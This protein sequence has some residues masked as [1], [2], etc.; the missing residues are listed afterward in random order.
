MLA[1]MRLEA[2]N[3]RWR[4]NLVTGEVRESDIDDLNTEFNKTNRST[5][6][7]VAMPTTNA[8]RR[9]KRA[10]I[11]RDYRACE[12]RQRDGALRNGIMVTASWVV[13]QCMPQSR[14]Y[15]KPRGDG[16]RQ[17]GDRHRDWSSYFLVFDATDMK[18]DR[19]L[20]VVAAKRVPVDFMRHGYPRG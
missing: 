15:L 6:I 16:Y 12:V 11:R 9:W 4:F 2:N 8:S 13:K 17:H 20:K 5:G 14:S 7:K 18:Q 19:S 1:Y 10:A 3:Y